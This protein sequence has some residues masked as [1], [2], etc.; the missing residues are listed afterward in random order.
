[1]Q[2]NPL[3]QKLGGFILQTGMTVNEITAK[4]AHLKLNCP[5]PFQDGWPQFL[6]SNHIAAHDSIIRCLPKTY[7][8]CVCAVILVI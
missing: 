1:M 6:Q 5:I 8:S 3:I 2:L 7:T 4:L